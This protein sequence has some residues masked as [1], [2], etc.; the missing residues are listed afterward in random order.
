MSY[1]V[2]FYKLIEVMISWNICFCYSL[3]TEIYGYKVYIKIT[4]YSIGLKGII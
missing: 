1:Y 2:F 4:T 3:V